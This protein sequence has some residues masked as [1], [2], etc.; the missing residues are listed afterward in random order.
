MKTKNR[1]PNHIMMRCQFS[2]AFV[3]LVMLTAAQTV[4]A[5]TKQV[6]AVADSSQQVF[7]CGYEVEPSFRGGV[8]GLKEYL[9]KTVVYP[10]KCIEDQIE[11]RVIVSFWVEKDGNISEAKVVRSVDPRLDCEALRAVWHMPKWQPA[12]QMGKV[13]RMR[14]AIPVD[15]RLSDVDK[16]KGAKRVTQKGKEKGDLLTVR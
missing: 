9:K 11:G 7:I 12:R 8:T 3:V 4:S 16:E 6:E 5:Q 13:V 10:W 2:L 1:K 14:Y 15:F